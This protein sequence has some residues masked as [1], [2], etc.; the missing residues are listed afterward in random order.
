MLLLVLSRIG[1]LSDVAKFNSEEHIRTPGGGLSAS[2]CI[3]AVSALWPLPLLT[4]SRVLQLYI[5]SN[6]NQ[7]GTHAKY[8]GDMAPCK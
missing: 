2:T 5:L 8:S 4:L 1:G 3:S 7:A 6:G